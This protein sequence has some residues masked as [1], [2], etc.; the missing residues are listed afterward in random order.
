ML[1]R[2]LSN[3][4]S[5]AAK[6]MVQ[7]DM[8]RRCVVRFCRSKLKNLKLIKITSCAES[9][10]HLLTVRSRAALQHYFKAL[11]LGYCLKA[12]LAKIAIQACGH[13]WDECVLRFPYLLN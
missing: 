3:G 4:W 13:V 6:F 1:F 7:P 11:L 5:L 10:V 12:D 2:M 9:T 8:I